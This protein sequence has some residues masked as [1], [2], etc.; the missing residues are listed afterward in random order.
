MMINIFTDPHLGTSRTAH[1]SPDS[2]KRL[3]AALSEA[4]QAACH[5]TY[6]NI[7]VGDLFDKTTNPES[8]IIQGIQLA[9][10]ATILAGNHDET[11][12]SGTVTSLSVV[13]AACPGQ[14]IQSS[15]V[16]VPYFEERDGMYFVPHHASQEIFLEALEMARLHAE[17]T[18]SNSV[19]FV[20]CNRGELPVQDDS[21]LVI[22]LALEDDLMETF[23]RVFYG[24]VHG[25]DSNLVTDS[26]QVISRGVVLGN[27]HPTSFGDV[28]SKYRYEYDLVTDKLQRIKIWDKD[29]LFCQVKL[30]EPLPVG[31]FQF[32][33]VIGTGER[34]DI[35]AFLQ[36]AWEQYPSA[37][38]IRN[39]CSVIGEIETV[40]EDVNL[41]D[42]PATIERD[43]EGTDML[44]LF[45]EIRSKL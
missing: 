18:D 10:K 38:G 26:E 36:A 12:R 43:L 27:T 42:L 20:H 40:I 34:A 37:Y 1:T 8:I 29:T 24:H 41:D 16:A 13:A 33:E 31:D 45:R 7:V 28:S 35:A 21:T 32:V 17:S 15:N 11:N 2:S 3:T 23:K 14:V 44:E 4:A 19:L 9:T 5:P 25:S 39:N 22:G 6:E 30:N